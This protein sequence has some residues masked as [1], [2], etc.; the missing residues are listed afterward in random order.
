IHW[1]CGRRAARYSALAAW[2]GHLRLLKKAEHS[3]RKL[4]QM[5][6]GVRFDCIDP[7]CG[8]FR[9]RVLAAPVAGSQ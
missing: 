4:L 7:L 5:K 3:S 6:V 9:Q 8:A 1:R 2:I